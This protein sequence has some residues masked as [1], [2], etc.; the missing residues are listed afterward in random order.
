MS[1]IFRTREGVQDSGICLRDLNLLAH[2][3]MIE[4]PTGSRCGGH[5]RCGA[6]RV[7]LDPVSERQV[8]PPTAIERHQL[9]AEDLARGVRLACQAFPGQDGLSIEATIE[10]TGGSSSR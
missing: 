8:N 1:V 9:S 5:G 6:D 2:A 3:Q 7:V 4:L 10:W